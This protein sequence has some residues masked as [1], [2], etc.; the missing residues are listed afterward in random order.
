MWR[1]ENINNLKENPENPRT[2]SPEKLAKLVKSIKDFSKM[3]ELRPLVVNE[4]LIVLGG[5]M[6]LKACKSAGIE[7]VPIILASE[8]TEA[9]QKEFII[10][11]NISFGDNDWEILATKW[12]L[13]EL[14]EWGMEIPD[15]VG[16]KDAVEDN[17]EIPG[18]IKTDIVKGD[19]FELTVNGLTHRLHCGDSTNADDV[20]KLLDGKELYLMVTDP[21]YGVEYDADWRNKALRKDGSPIDGRAIGK[22]SNDDN[23]DWTLAWALSPARV[24]YIWHAGK[25]CG[26]V[27]DSLSK[28]DYE[29]RSQIIWVKS[30]FA[31]GRGDYHW[32]H[33]P[34]WYA[35]KKGNKGNWASDRKQT[36]VWDIAKPSKSET[37]HSTQKPV[38]CMAK[39]ISHHDGDVYD[40]FGGSGTTLVAAAQLNR[41]CFM[42]ELDEKYCQVII[43]RFTK[44]FPE[45]AIKRNGIEWSNKKEV[46]NV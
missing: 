33:E 32:K 8:L 44:L 2:I 14:A 34:C 15:F 1:L 7:Q 5:N 26:I 25:Y 6:R 11:D 16:K 37:G 17:Y 22:V 18:E 39:P 38:E 36:T 35:V 12:D 13:G 43:D 10:K 31:I 41:R 30:N 3:L 27:S 46:V 45:T 9:E 29:I 28:A 21:P 42:Q 23:A 4:A 20:G 24:A 40:P 19:L